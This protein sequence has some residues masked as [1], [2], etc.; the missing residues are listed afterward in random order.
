MF[1]NSKGSPQK[2]FLIISLD[3]DILGW[4][5]QSRIIDSIYFYSIFLS[6]FRPRNVTLTLKPV[7]IG[8]GQ[9]SYHISIRISIYRR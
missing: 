1:I 6:H 3:I 2:I 5:N 7:I 8:A 9:D 4:P